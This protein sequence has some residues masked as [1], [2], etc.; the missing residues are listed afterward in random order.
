MPYKRRYKRK[1]RRRRRRRG[2]SSK[3]V[4]RMPLV[5]PDVMYVPMRY[6]TTFTMVNVGGFGNH[7]FRQNS[8]FDPDFTGTGHQPLGHDQWANFYTAYEVLS[9]SIKF[10]VLPPDVNPIQF[11]IY[12]SLGSGS[13]TSIATAI[14][15]PYSKFK[16]TN[17][18]TMTARTNYLRNSMSIRKFEGRTTA[19]VNYTSAFG[20][21]PANTR[22]WICVI[23][24]M[25]ATS[26][27]DI[28]CSVQIIYRCKLFKR[29]TLSA[30]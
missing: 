24:S 12:P 28:L 19:S 11:A 26:I 7:E 2:R 10:Q 13:V 29:I 3:L 30:S 15:Q 8:I 18:T 20:A 1:R 23:G 9:S 16:Q 25:T 5:M 6:S 22:F 17:D 4:L 27:S 21:S 14:E